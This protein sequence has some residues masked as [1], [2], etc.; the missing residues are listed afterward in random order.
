[1]KISAYAVTALLLS[2]THAQPARAQEIGEK[3]IA[4]GKFS[5]DPEGGYL[6]LDG[7]LRQTIMLLKMPDQADID[8]YKKDW[9]EGFA[10]AK[11][12]YAKQL[13]S[14]ESEKKAA[15]GAARIS[16]K[17]IE[18][19]P[20]TFTIGDIET[21]TKVRIG[22]AYVFN[23]D[24]KN[25]HYSYLTK[26]QPGT[27]IYYGPVWLDANAGYVGTCYCMGSVKFEVK[28]GV[29]TDAGN[30]LTAALYQ[31]P[32]TPPHPNISF[33][34]EGTFFIFRKIKVE[35][36]KFTW[37]LPASLA[38]FPSVRADFH[39]AGKMDNHFGISIARMPAIPGVLGYRRDKVID[40]KATA[41]P[42]A[43]TAQP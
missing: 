25:F 9:D 35:V 37:G 43:S 5:F 20:E 34:P 26:L 15:G 1:M 27:Y 24:D 8:T 41:T 30:F 12:K 18:P 21:R 31:A 29:I 11:A 22:P 19:T 2:F 38:S 17:P 6:Y 7:W 33:T 13:A 10:K 42:V 23:K 4:A 39:A 16:E 14:W 3:Q 40:L 28:P 36:G 32:A